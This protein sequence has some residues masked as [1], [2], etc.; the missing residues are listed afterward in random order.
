MNLEHSLRNLAKSTYW[1]SLYRASKENGIQLF[2]N[3]TNL[4]G[5]QVVFLYWLE[6]YSFLYDLIAKK[7]YPFLDD[8]YIKID[9]RVDAF[10]YYRKRQNELELAKI[11]EEQLQ[12]KTKFKKKTGKQTYFDV[13]FA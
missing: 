4:S 7:E 10:L 8:K 5:L 13:E 2:E 1:Q 6:V 11:K 3:K 12:Q 9:E